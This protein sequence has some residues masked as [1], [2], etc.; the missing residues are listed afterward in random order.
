LDCWQDLGQEKADASVV[1]FGRLANR[2]LI[3][4]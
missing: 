3:I 1:L 4:W 2:V